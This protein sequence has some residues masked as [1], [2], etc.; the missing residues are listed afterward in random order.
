LSDVQIG[1]LKGADLVEADLEFSMSNKGKLGQ[2]IKLKEPYLWQQFRGKN[3]EKFGAGFFYPLLSKSRKRKGGQELQRIENIS[4]TDSLPPPRKLHDKR[5]WGGNRKRGR[6]KKRDR[7]APLSPIILILTV[8]KRE[9][10]I[11]KVT[12][13]DRRNTT[14]RE[15]T[16]PEG[17]RRI[18]IPSHEKS[19]K[20]KLKKEKTRKDAPGEVSTKSGV[21]GDPISLLRRGGLRKDNFRRK[22]GGTWH[23]KGLKAGGG[24]GGPQS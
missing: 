16:K 3:Y 19:V 18:H 20:E 13:P 22:A 11:T 24:P 1:K 23:K 7:D 4:S 10:E 5:R 14:G 2:R 8:R 21:E 17:K 12:S 6:K 9:G 15:K